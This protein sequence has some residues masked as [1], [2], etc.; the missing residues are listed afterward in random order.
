MKQLKKAFLAEFNK[1]FTAFTT[2]GL[3]V[4][5]MITYCFFVYWLKLAYGDLIMVLGAM[6]FLTVSFFFIDLW[7]SYHQEKEIIE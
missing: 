2:W 7:W 5:F 6:L 4:V 1:I 3:G